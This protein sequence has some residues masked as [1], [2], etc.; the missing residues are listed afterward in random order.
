MRR[1]QRRSGSALLNRIPIWIINL[2]KSQHRLAFQHQQFQKHN[3]R[4]TRVPAVRGW[5][6]EDIAE[7]TRGLHL[8]SN[9]QGLSPHEIGLG[10]HSMSDGQRGCA[11]SH[12]Y[13]LQQMVA[14]NIPAVLVLEDDAVLCH[15][16][17][18]E[19]DNYFHAHDLS[20]DVIYLGGQKSAQEVQQLMQA[21]TKKSLG[22]TLCA[23]ALIYTLQGA[24]RILQYI[25][26]FGLYVYDIMLVLAARQGRLR[27]LTYIKLPDSKDLAEGLRVER[28]LG[29][30][31]QSAQFLSEISQI[32][33]TRAANP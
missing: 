8:S 31:Y 22:A 26:E 25:A 3:M 19:F 9:V 30:C 2:E 18:R 1:V 12:V 11:L 7:H 23:H 33:R 13:I 20:H 17:R 27:C 14:K 5:V 10:W 24:R 6:P 4:F 21:R 16:F 28:S 15:N 29:L 32:E